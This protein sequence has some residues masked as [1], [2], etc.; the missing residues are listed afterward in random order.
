MRHK[1][2]I[3]LI[4]II[5]LISSLYSIVSPIHVKADNDKEEPSTKQIYRD[6]I[7]RSH[8]DHITVHKGQQV[9]DLFLFG[10]SADI[11][12][13]VKSDVVTINT[14]LTLR[15]TA[16]VNE[17]VVMLG[18][19]LTQEDGAR[20][21]EGIYRIDS[22]QDVI[23][24]IFMGFAA[25]AGLEMAKL[26][27]L[28]VLVLSAVIINM[29]LAEHIQKVIDFIAPQKNAVIGIGIG[30]AIV[31]AALSATFI[32]ARWGIPLAALLSSI[33]AILSFIGFIILSP[34]I[35]SK[36][37]DKMNWPNASWSTALTG[38]LVICIAAAIPVVGVLIIAVTL[39]LSLGI[40]VSYI[41][42]L[43]NNRK[44]TLKA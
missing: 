38:S 2:F 6:G 29:L 8:G 26:M 13:T 22:G 34:A 4:I 7:Q 28:I 41:F 20:I 25:F 42:H 32:L 1:S 31:W 35:G 15:S 12:G 43:I 23:N 40:S 30:T 21:K 14:D 9:K 16:T 19:R 27:A 5:A 37:N 17:K 36:I 10:G 39:I 44:R 33:A 24:S 3:T 11:A 18:G